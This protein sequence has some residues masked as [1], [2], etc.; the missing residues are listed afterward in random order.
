MMI[1]WDTY[2][3]RCSSLPMLMT[4][5]RSKSDILSETAKACLR[6]IWIKE[7]FGREKIDTRNKFVD[8]GISCESDSLDLVKEVL[9]V[10][11]FKNNK[12]YSNDWIKGT[13][14]IVTVMEIKDI[15]TSWDIWTF[16]TVDEDKA[17]KDYYYQL[18]G[19]MWLTK[20]P[21]SELIYCLVDTPEEIIND[22]LYRLSFK[23]KDISDN[24]ETEM[25]VKRNYL[26]SDIEPKLRLKNYKFSYT[27]AETEAVKGILMEARKYL[28]SL[29]L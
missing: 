4:K 28:A 11:Y 7:M 29:S 15:K 26:F 6:E 2:K 20:S 23:Y 3:F 25:K 22:E 21:N 24:P 14:D 13:P 1:D 5:S 18:L 19:Y 27:E 17:Y 8:K 12:E 9:G 10:N 16:A